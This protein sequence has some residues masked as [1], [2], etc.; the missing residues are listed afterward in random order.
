MSDIPQ[1]DLIEAGCFET[2]CA[3]CGD[4]W[5]CT[6]QRPVHRRPGSANERGLAAAFCSQE[7]A[8]GYDARMGMSPPFAKC[9]E[10]FQG[11]KEKDVRW[12]QGEKGVRCPKCHPE[13]VP[14]GDWPDN[15]PWREK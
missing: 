8:E 9:G 7:C 4:K 3:Q 11:I 5:V 13:P 14:E 6:M 12:I 2:T 15:A 10:C 1:E